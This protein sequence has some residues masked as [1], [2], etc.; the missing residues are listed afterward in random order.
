LNSRRPDL[1]MRPS[2]LRQLQNHE[3]RLTPRGI[4]PKTQRWTELSDQTTYHLE[5]EE[6][7]LRNTFVNS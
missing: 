3:N 5:N 4:G 7:I 2:F 6:L 1:E